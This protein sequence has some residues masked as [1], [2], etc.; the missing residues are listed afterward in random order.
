MRTYTIQHYQ[1]AG[2]Y[3]GLWL[4]L[5]GLG[6][7]RGTWDTALCRSSAYRI[8]ADMRRQGAQVRVCHD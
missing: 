7:N 2:K 3:A 1:T 4:T 5:A 8:A 6:R